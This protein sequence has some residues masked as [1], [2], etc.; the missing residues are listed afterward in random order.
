M[1]QTATT[2][3]NNLGVRGNTK[4]PPQA[5]KWLG[6]IYYKD[7][8]D[9]INIMRQCDTRKWQYIFGLEECPT[10]NRKHLQYYIEST[11]G[12]AI[13]STSINML[14]DKHHKEIAKGSTDENVGYCG[15]DMD[16]RSNWNDKYI[17]ECVEKYRE[18]MERIKGCKANKKQNKSD[19]EIA[20]E[21]ENE[22]I[23]DTIKTNME[24][25]EEIKIAH[26]EMWLK[27]HINDPYDSD[28]T[29]YD[30]DSDKEA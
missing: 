25:L 12:S 6:T 22:Y 21:I 27:E 10:T 30:I 29:D 4:N 26:D 18:K 9:I 5:R 13:R 24:A 8:N 14:W 3:T 23:I 2:A 16:Y 1:R 7:E 11:G 20:N 28:T 15:K 17:L 19:A